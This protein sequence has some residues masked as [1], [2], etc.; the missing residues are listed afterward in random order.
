MVTALVR[1]AASECEL[2]LVPVGINGETVK[3]GDNFAELVFYDLNIAETVS[4]YA[5]RRWAL[6]Y[7]CRG[8]RGE[9]FAGNV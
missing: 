1:R 3:L 5:V 7:S 9:R 2:R 6:I 8:K 4:Y